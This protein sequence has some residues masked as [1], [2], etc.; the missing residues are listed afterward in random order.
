MWTLYLFIVELGFQLLC[1][2]NLAYGFHKVFL[3]TVISLFSDSK[4]A[5]KSTPNE[6]HNS[7]TDFAHLGHTCFC[8]NVTQISTVET[9]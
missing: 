5:Y 8:A 6:W 3:D 2:G 9:V 7:Y 4:H 1:I